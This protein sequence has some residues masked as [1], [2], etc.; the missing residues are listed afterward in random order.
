MYHLGVNRDEDLSRV[1]KII[2]LSPGSVEGH[3]SDFYGRKWAAAGRFSG[4]FAVD[5]GFLAV[6]LGSIFEG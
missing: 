5:S 1:L 2:D 3:L 6:V 4:R